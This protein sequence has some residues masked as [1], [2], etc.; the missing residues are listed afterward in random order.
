MRWWSELKYLVRKL[1]RGRAERELEEEIGT[2]LEME[3]QEK[4]NDGLSR[5]EA[6]YAAKRAFGS[7]ALATEDSRAWWGFGMLEEL[8]QDLHYGA[9]MLVKQPGF[10]LVVVVTLALGIGANTV[11]FSVVNAV[12]LR[13][14]PYSQPERVIA[15][16][17]SRGKPSPTQGATLP[18]NFQWWR[19]QSR[20]F[21]DFA[22]TQGIGYRLTE[23]QEATSG[24]GLEVTPNLFSLLGVSA[25]RGRTLAPGDETAGAKPVVLSYRLWQSS[26]GGDE[27]VVGRSIKVGAE[28]YTVVG[29]MPPQFV[30]PPRVSLASDVKARDC[31][32]WVPLAIDQQRL[33][34]T[35]RNYFAYGRLRTDVTLAQAQSEMNA[36]ASRL[37]EIYP[38]LN[39]QLSIHLAALPELA[40]RQVRPLLSVLLG[41]V[42][43]IL[44][45]ACANVA[46]LLLAR[47]TARARE[48]A[49][50]S[51]L[52]ATRG[53]V[54][55]QILTE[56]A[57][58]GLLSGLAGLALAYGGLR[59]LSSVAEVRSPHPIAIDL[60]VLGFTLAL[61]LVTSLI[62]GSWAAW[63][64]ATVAISQSLQDAGRSGAD[65]VRLGRMRGW[66]TVA[67]V[68]LSLMLL[69]GAGLLIRT[70]WS[71][72][73]VDPGFRAERVLTMDVALPAK[74][75]SGERV[76]AA[77]GE[78]F[79]RVGSLPGVVSV[80]A[81][82]R[83]PVR[84]EPYGESFQIEGRPMR[85]SN[86][87]LEMQYRV[88]TPGYFSAMQIPLRQGRLLSEQDTETS[89]RV[90]VISERLARLHFPNE[91]PI[92]RR[93]TINDP[94]TGPWEE[95][96]GV[97]SDVKHWGLDAEPPPEFYVSY[98]QHWRRF[99]TFT[100]RTGGDPLR[101]A[102]AV[103]AE[104]RAFDKDLAP[105]QVATME[106][107]ISVSLTQRRLNMMILGVLA[108]LAVVLAACGLY[109]VLAY[110]VA[111][112]TRE[113]GIRLA[114]GAQGG[115]V[116][117]MVVRQ[118]MKLT[119]IGVLL[120]VSGAL[121]LTR[122]LKMLL[123]GVNATDPLTFAGVA[124]LLVIVA[125][126]A[127]WIPARRATK[128]DPMVALRFE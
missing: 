45:I 113:I 20:S 67:Q 58:L 124:L 26:F 51:A 36:F 9:R 114:L 93:V 49:I 83:L 44:L 47:G 77:Y 8:C 101:L 126:V 122:S 39:D 115:D 123:F 65:G 73:Q 121:A 1:N 59:L 76:V 7:V 70:L 29:I 50:R 81:T 98:R 128:V 92:G 54:L 46:N 22:L 111:Q 119:L 117:R 41:A 63:Q 62:C 110:T 82:Q 11:I 120:G 80:G 13:P 55:R 15:I 48:L 17:D 112:R 25:L 37:Q 85:S 53:R 95:I 31:D 23:T 102:S 103:R 42:A 5:E 91:S 12:L 4:I 75:S 99:M 19:E 10:T 107:V 35:G 40:T 88:V 96:V 6:L 3:A 2:H 24:A 106:Q 60:P 38:K 56:C 105:E 57:L 68:A 32:L 74:Y 72:L 21:S 28:A 78:L 79:K 18:R 64:M 127:C 69:I 87:L 89:P 97:V 86:D 118:G 34:Q 125:L 94:K 100:V 43:F 66:L 27:S 30:F 61:S 16:W 104:V 33:Q 90:V 109:G 52:G 84:G 71:L 108:A 116:L 14:L